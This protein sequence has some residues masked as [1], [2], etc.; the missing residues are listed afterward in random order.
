MTTPQTVIATWLMG[1][2]AQF[3]HLGIDFGDLEAGLGTPERGLAAL[4]LG[5]AAGGAG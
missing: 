4:Y 3:K 1:V 5:L 2:A